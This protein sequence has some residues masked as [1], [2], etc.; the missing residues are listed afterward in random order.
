MKKDYRIGCFAFINGICCIDKCFCS[1]QKNKETRLKNKFMPLKQ[2]NKIGKRVKKDDFLDAKVGRTFVTPLNREFIFN[3]RKEGRK[4]IFI[5]TYRGHNMQVKE[6]DFNLTPI[7]D[8]LMIM[9]NEL[10]DKNEVID[11]LNQ[12]PIN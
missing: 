8:L 6:S 7:D 9:D 1:G 12:Q 10:N 2:N 5:L 11:P 3:Y 4:Y